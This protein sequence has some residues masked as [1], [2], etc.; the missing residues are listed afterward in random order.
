[1]FL[2]TF[3]PWSRVLPEKLIAGF[4]LDRKFLA[5]YGA[6]SSHAPNLLLEDQFSYYPGSSRWSPIPQVSPR[7]PAS[8]YAIYPAH[9]I[10]IEWSPEWYMVRSTEHKALCYAVFS[11]PLLPHPSWAQISSSALYSQTPAAY[12]PPS[13][14]ATNLHNHTKQLAKLYFCIS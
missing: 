3:T 13:M 8:I 10:L 12:I 6:P 4:H 5:F 2:F 14:W 11:T 1:V 9:L 7:K